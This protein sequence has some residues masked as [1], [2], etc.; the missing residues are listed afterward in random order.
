MTSLL[1]A[2]LS[3]FAI[4]LILKWSEER[5]GDRL[6]VAGSN[7]VAAV[8]LGVVLGADLLPADWL[9]FGAL[10]GLGFVAGF[11][12]LMEGMKSIGLAITASVARV[13]TIGP[14]I[15]SVLVYAERPSP[16]VIT[17]IVLGIASFLLFGL[18]SSGS[19]A[20]R[21]DEADRNDPV[22]FGSI[23]LIAAIFIVMTINDFAMKVAQVND[24]DRASLLVVVFGA[25]AL[26]CWGIV[27]VRSIR[28]EPGKRS[29]SIRT[30]DLVRGFLLGIPNFLSSWFIIAALSEIAASIVFPVS[31]A[32]G[33]L[34]S[35]IAGMVIWRERHGPLG[36]GGI[37]LA[38]T[39]V[40][41]LGIG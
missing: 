13:A 37:V 7:Y 6:V 16:I 5:R 40:I 19:S 41:L 20:R 36:V 35:V 26:L 28:S 34:L 21:R 12:L 1:L 10:V 38:V 17:G 23:L 31:S 39:A 29:A 32:A 8:I 22:R 24:V 33:V 27:A 3:S 14:V 30:S 18:E 4:A 25:A 11:L 2:I 15:L 9:L